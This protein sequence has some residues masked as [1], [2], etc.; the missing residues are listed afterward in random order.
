MSVSGHVELKPEAGCEKGE[1]VGGYRDQAITIAL[2][3]VGSWELLLCFLVVFAAPRA[4]DMDVTNALPSLPTFQFSHEWLLLG[5]FQIG[6]RE[7]LWAADPLEHFGGFRS[8]AYDPNAVFRSSLP[9]N[10]TT[11]WSNVTAQLTEPSVQRNGATLSVDFQNV[12]WEALRNAYGWAAYQWQ[13]WIRGEIYVQS[14]KTE[15]YTLSAPQ[16]LEWWIDHVHYFG[17]DFYDYSRASP[18]LRLTP[19]IHRIDVRIVRDV[20]A[21]GGVERPAMNITLRLDYSYAGLKHVGKVL[22]SDTINSPSGQGLASPFGSALLRNDGDEEVTISAVEATHNACLADLWLTEE[23]RI[24]PGQTRP[25]AFRVRCVRLDWRIR[26]DFKFRVAGRDRIETL[27]ILAEPM[28]RNPGEPHKVTFPHPGG[29]VSYAILRPPSR[30]AVDTVPPNSTLP[31]LLGFHGAGV[32][33]EW[34]SVRLALQPLPDLP[35]WVLYPTGVTP[36]AGDDWHAFGFPDVE[37]AVEMIPD[38]IEVNEWQGPGVN[39]QQWLVAGHSNGGQGVWYALTHWPDKVIAASPISGYSSIQN[40]VPYTF[41]QPSDPLRTS[42]IQSGLLPYRHELLLANAKGIPVLQQHGGADDNVPPY[43]SRLQSQLIREAGANSEYFEFAGKPHWWDGV[44]TTTPLR[45]FYQQQIDLN[46]ANVGRAPITFQDFSLVVANP[47]DTGSKHGF[48]VL[49]LINPAQIGRLDVSFDP[50][51]L[52]CAIS[53]AN[54]TSSDN[55]RPS[56]RRMGSQLGQMDSILRTQGP[57]QILQHSKQAHHIAL[58]ISRNLCQYFAADTIIS[59]DWDE[60]FTSTGNIISVAIGNDLPSGFFKD[61]PIQ[62]DQGRSIS[63]RHFFGSPGHYDDLA[64]LGL[65]AIFLRPLPMGRLELVVWGSDASMLEVAARL[66]PMMPGSGQPDFVVMDKTMLAKGLNGV[67][68]M[69][70]FDNFW[71]VSKNSFF[72]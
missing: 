30:R 65:A 57:F 42:I 72:G 59:E 61:H 4:T 69:G 37:A 58:Q 60:A 39:T 47:G 7:A 29:I 1:C 20:R 8:L 24:A 23:I 46:I 32:E 45:D 31:V 22:I 11:G 66:V 10:G 3:G 26:L 16:L 28:R 35:A 14:N 21:F 18:V 49:N 15:I 6:T 33:A 5:P 38:W 53:T 40:Y 62:I 56:I 34:D 12:D 25:V 70:F 19:G 54:A 55:T 50:T 17:G 13:A 48:R 51:T 64:D 36:W 27:T 52:A 71:E 2:Y 9:V 68:A 43:N 67:L 63:I 44:F 41:W